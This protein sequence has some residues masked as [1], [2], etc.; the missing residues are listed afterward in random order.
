MREKE[1]STV[2][3]VST[4]V[5]KYEVSISCGKLIRQSFQDCAPITKPWRCPIPTANNT[6]LNVDRG[7]LSR[8]RQV[9]IEAAHTTP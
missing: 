4:G 7:S 5:W 9:L 6:V 8:S 1:R 3:R 2:S